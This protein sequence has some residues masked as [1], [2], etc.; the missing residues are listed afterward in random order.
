VHRTER[1]EKPHW[2]DSKASAHDRVRALKLCD[3]AV[4]YQHPEELLGRVI[5]PVS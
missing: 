1:L 2:N 4:R 3:I 5:L